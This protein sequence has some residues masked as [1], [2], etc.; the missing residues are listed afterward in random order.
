MGRSVVH[1]HKIYSILWLRRQNRPRTNEPSSLFLF[2]DIFEQYA[3]KYVIPSV[4]AFAP[5]YR[6]TYIIFD[7]YITNSLKV[8]T[9]SKRGQGAKRRLSDKGKL[10]PVWRRFLRNN[11]NKTD[12]FNYC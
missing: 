6:R 4:E 5:I 11:Y 2:I 1:S 10:P 9:M 12:L 8:E 7:V 3:T